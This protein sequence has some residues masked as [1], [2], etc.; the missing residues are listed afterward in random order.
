[1]LLLEIGWSLLS[2]LSIDTLML[3]IMPPF[4]LW[5]YIL[6][7][8]MRVKLRVEITFYQNKVLLLEIRKPSI[9]C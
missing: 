7:R 3:I 4:V 6:L 9:S 2:G 1:M 5:I 8:V